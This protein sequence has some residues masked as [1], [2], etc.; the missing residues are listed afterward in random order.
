[1]EYVNLFLSFFKIG[2]LAFGGGYAAL[3][4]I[5]DE[6]VR[7]HGWMSNLEFLDLLSL[8]QIT[9]GPIA[10][11]SA[12]YIGYKLLGL[13][14]AISATL[15][16]TLPSFL[17]VFVIINL[18]E[19]VLRNSKYL[20]DALKIGIVTPILAA[21]ISLFRTT[22]VDLRTLIL[23]IVLFMLMRYRKIPL[24]VFI[25]LSGLLGMILRF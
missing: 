6:I 15:G 18:I 11:N 2:F 9:P 13:P 17:W 1:M 5:Q 4:M 10:V 8:A 3:G 21:G 24:I 16:V 12:T 23:A 25:G 14:G 22:V 19:R 7:I 20:L